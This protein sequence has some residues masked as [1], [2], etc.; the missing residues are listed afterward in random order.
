MKTLYYVIG[1]AVDDENNVLGATIETETA[2]DDPNSP[3]FDDEAQ[4]WR[5][6]REDEET[7]DSAVFGKI[8]ELLG[9]EFGS[10]EGDEDEPSSAP[11]TVN[12]VF[13]GVLCEEDP[14][15]EGYCA[16]HHMHHSRG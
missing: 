1:V 10:I 11:E 14:E 9:D 13:P 7:L 3:V 12:A 8:N 2:L 4:E 6:V 16:Y 5:A 15:N